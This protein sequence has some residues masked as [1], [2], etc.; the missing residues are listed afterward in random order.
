VIRYLL[1][2][3]IISNALKPV[4][5]PGLADWMEQQLDESLFI[6]A[7]TVAEI[8]RGMLL[9]PAGRR[10]RE[11]ESWFAGPS[12]P[13]ALFVGRI[14]AFDE[15]AASIWA[16]LMAEGSARGR[17]RSGLDMILAATAVANDCIMVTANEKDF[18]GVTVV[19][20]LKSS[21]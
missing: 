16:R 7:L 6:S 20:P 2:T 3:N 1:D 5:S 8:Q 18:T 12:G 4:P 13:Q 21:H 19:N 14:L 9:L 15:T 10:R 11:L 17:P